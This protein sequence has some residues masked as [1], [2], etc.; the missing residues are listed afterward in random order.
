VGTLA[1][2]PFTA[3]FHP[4]SAATLYLVSLSLLY[5]FAERRERESYALP[6]R[7]QQTLSVIV[8]AHNEADRIA[9]C[10]GS[11]HGWA[12][13]IVVLDSG[14]TDGTVE[15]ARRHATATHV[16]DWPG[17][18]PQKQRALELATR[19]W[20]LSIDA[21]EEVTPELR[22]DIDRVLTAEPDCVGYRLP[23]GVIVY[24]KL[25]DFGRSARAPLRL[26]RREGSRFTDAQVH[27]TVALP[28]GSVGRLR[29]RLLHYTQR[30]FGHAL[31]KVARYGWL[32]ARQRYER[33]VRAG[34]LAGAV[35][36]ALIVFLQV[37]VIRLGFLDGGPGFLAAALYG[38]VAFD[39]YAG[40]WALRR[41]AASAQRQR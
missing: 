32:G 22:H 10:L 31:E 34:G 25:L 17:Y 12:D 24:G 2:S 39:K 36:R 23:W 19:A 18:G 4:I 7:R 27:E 15:I 28:P 37:Y 35:A 1:L 41:E 8:I 5:R 38:Q 33:G 20:V 9:R 26:F 13:E 16:T 29:G 21:D 6:V 14:S 11:V 40:L 30:D 3:V